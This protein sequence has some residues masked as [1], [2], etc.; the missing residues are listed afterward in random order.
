MPQPSP[1][2]VR[3]SPDRALLAAAARGDPDALRQLRARHWMSLYA[4]TYGIV[5]DASDAEEVVDAAFD[6]AWLKASHYDPTRGSV[7]A[8]LADVARSRARGVIRARDWPRRLAG[9]RV[10]APWAG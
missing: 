6:E 9:D 1:A 2:A 5:T 3:P 4:L 10:E 8:W 7:Y